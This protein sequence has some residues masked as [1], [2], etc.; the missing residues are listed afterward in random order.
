MI[1]N[2]PYS[3]L[4]FCTQYLQPIADGITKQLK[5][6][7]SIMV[8]QPIPSNSNVEVRNV[9][10]NWPGG[11]SSHKWPAHDPIG[12]QA[13]EASVAKY[14]MAVFHRCDLYNV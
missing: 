12:Y 13:A 1:A 4:A 8:I 5:S 6:A 9:H 14:G 11:L 7:V 2:P 3:Q 10:V